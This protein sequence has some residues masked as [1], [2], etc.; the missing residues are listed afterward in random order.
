MG[1][2][3]LILIPIIIIL[4]LSYNYVIAK[5][6]SNY[7]NISKW[8]LFFIIIIF[9]PLSLPILIYAL[10]KK[11]TEKNLYIIR[12]IEGNIQCTRID[13]KCLNKIYFI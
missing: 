11:W 5:F 6:S 13:Y 2:A 7:I 8:S 9:P 4:Y 1:M 3:G 10:I 12:T